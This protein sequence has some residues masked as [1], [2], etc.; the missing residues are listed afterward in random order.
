ML[1][2]VTCGGPLDY[3]QGYGYSYRYNVIAVAVPS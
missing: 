1:V 2:M 3:I